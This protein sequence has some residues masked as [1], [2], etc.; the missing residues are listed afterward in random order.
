MGRKTFLKNQQGNIQKG[1]A[2][3]QTTAIQY[4]PF[5][6]QKECRIKL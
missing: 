1:E 3:A 2:Y 5:D 4:T 6:I